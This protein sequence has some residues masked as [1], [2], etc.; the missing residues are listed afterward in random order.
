MGAGFS[1]DP[2]VAIGSALPIDAVGSVEPAWTTA[3]LL[4]H[5]GGWDEL[6]MVAV[7]VLLFAFLVRLANRRAGALAEREPDGGEEGG[8]EPAETSGPT[9]RPQPSPRRGL[10]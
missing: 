7:P 1:I 8:D 6:L 3:P 2:V 4:A 5:Q 9:R 10:H